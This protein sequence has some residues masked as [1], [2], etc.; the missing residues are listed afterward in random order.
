MGFCD[1]L[2][3]ECRECFDDD[4]C[5]VAEPICDLEDFEC[6]A[7]CETAGDCEN[8]EL[9][10]CDN[11]TGRCLECF[12]NEDC[13]GEICTDFGLCVECLASDDCPAGEPL[14]RPDGECVECSG[15]ADCGGG[16]P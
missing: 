8:D 6:V 7:A 13:D 1:V 15:D 4:D 10:M 14:C 2:D 11:E 12:S 9:P 3:G 5:G 16:E